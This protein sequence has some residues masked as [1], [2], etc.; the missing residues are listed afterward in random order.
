MKTKYT[1]FISDVHLTAAKPEL[2]QYFLNFLTSAKTQKAEAVYILG[3]LFEVW[4]GDDDHTSFHQ[5]IKKALQSLSQHCPLYFMHGNRDFLIGQRFAQECSLELLPDFLCMELYN[6]RVVLMH[7]DLLCTDDQRYQQARQ[8][9][10]S[11][12]FQA[13]TL[14]KPL[15]LRRLLAKYYRWQSQRYHKQVTTDAIMDVNLD[16]T[17]T[18]FETYSAKVLIHGHTH[19]PGI[20][21]L[22][23]SHGFCKRITLGD[24][25]QEPY[26]LYYD[27]TGNHNLQKI[28]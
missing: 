7:G 3:D 21:W 13:N 15:W 22:K 2:T 16:T 20:H 17:K 11:S 6:T 24:W 1:I 4:I 9:F 19:R 25:H 26:I 23:T 27:E 14:A 5:T 28:Q 10:T 12:D 8:K 18:I